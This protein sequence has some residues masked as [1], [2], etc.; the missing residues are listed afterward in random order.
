MKTKQK[1]EKLLSELQERQCR[2]YKIFC[3]VRKAVA[4]FDGKPIT[5]RIATAVEKALPE[6]T[7]YYER[8]YGMFH[9][10]IWGNGIEYGDRLSLLL[11]YESAPTFHIGEP[12]KQ[13]SGFEYYSCCY[14]SAEKERIDQTQKLLVDD[15]KLQR[16]ADVVD[17][18]ISARAAWN[19]LYGMG[20]DQI[21][22]YWLIGKELLNNK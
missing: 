16:V 11:G 18:L 20:P 1:I 8:Q 3:A 19:K 13:H 22:G 17:N 14:G 6:Y 7:V 2:T 21:P 9:V 4:P 10:I 15:R 12:D 5:K